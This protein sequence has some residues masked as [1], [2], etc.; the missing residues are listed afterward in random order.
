MPHFSR[1]RTESETKTKR[2]SKISLRFYRMEL[3][4]FCGSL[5]KSAPKARK[6]RQNKRQIA[7]W[8]RLGGTYVPRNA[9]LGRSYGAWIGEWPGTDGNDG[10]RTATNIQTD[11]RKPSRPTQN[12]NNKKT[13]RM[14]HIRSQALAHPATSSRRSRRFSRSNPAPPARCRSTCRTSGTSRRSIRAF[15]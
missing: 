11:T 1:R 9:I 2:E 5:K 6:P 12:R 3:L 10:T 4:I 15:P 8:Y 13:G 14:V 7:V